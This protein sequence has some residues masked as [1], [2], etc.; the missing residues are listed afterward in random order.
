LDPEVSLNRGK[1]KNDVESY[2]SRA[3]SPTNKKTWHL[4]LSNNKELLIAAQRMT[5]IRI[6]SC[7]ES[8]CQKDVV[9]ILN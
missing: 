3:E 2:S 4:S 7:A 8:D 1:T 5:L 6:L 9:L